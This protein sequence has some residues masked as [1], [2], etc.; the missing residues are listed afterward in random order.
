VVR[1]WNYKLCNQTVGLCFSASKLGCKQSTKRWVLSSLSVGEN[2]FP[3]N[4]TKWLLRPRARMKHKVC[5]IF[6]AQWYLNRA[7]AAKRAPSSSSTHGASHPCVDTP[8]L[9]KEPKIPACHMLLLFYVASKPVGEVLHPPDQAGQWS[10]FLCANML[11][12]STTRQIRQQRWGFCSTSFVYH[13]GGYQIFC[14]NLVYTCSCR[15]R[16]SHHIV[17]RLKDTQNIY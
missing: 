8:N 4:Q 2:G 14:G 5:S 9:S 12:Y 16:S 6:L 10:P 3:V 1:L 11:S 13:R 7:Q 15:P 17:N